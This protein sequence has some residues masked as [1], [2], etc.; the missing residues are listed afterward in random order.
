MTFLSLCGVLLCCALLAFLLREAHSPL[1]RLLCVACAV[2]VTVRLLSSYSAV[3]DGT[4]SLLEGGGIGEAARTLLKTIG[5]ALLCE[6]VGDVC[7]D[8]GES[9]C[10]SRVELCG[11]LEILALALPLVSRL[12]SELR[13]L[14][15]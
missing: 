3:L 9:A 2:L 14:L 10:A 12:L 15:V 13:E 7:R 11:K 1:A 4:I 5:V 8:L 6:T